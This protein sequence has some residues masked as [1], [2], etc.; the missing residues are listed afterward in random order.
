[1]GTARLV[2]QVVGI[3]C[4]APARFRANRWVFVVCVPACCVVS[5][6]ANRI[7]CVPTSAVVRHFRS[8]TVRV[9]PATGQREPAMIDVVVAG[10]SLARPPAAVLTHPQTKPDTL[11]RCTTHVPADKRTAAKIEA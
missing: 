2:R 5:M 8:F 11:I 4:V 10:R 3:V 9:V 7:V 6:S 1:M